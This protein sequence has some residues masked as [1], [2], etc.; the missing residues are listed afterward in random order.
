MSLLA[1][2]VLERIAEQAFDRFEFG[3]G[4]GAVSLDGL[5]SDRVSDVQI[6]PWRA[7]V[8]CGLG[9]H[10]QCMPDV[11]P[12]EERTTSTIFN[13]LAPCRESV[14]STYTAD[15]FCKVG[16][17][18]QTSHALYFFRHRSTASS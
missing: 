9:A 13:E 2:Q 18:Y 11:R 6:R 1:K 17:L 15:W 14:F 10:V 12:A 16:N 5:D 4:D 8:L 3:N 7:F